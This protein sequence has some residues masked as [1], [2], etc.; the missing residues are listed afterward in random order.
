MV[1]TEPAGQSDAGLGEANDRADHW[2]HPTPASGP[3]DEAAARATGG[4]GRFTIG[5]GAGGQNAVQDNGLDAV[6]WANVNSLSQLQTGYWWQRQ[7]AGKD[8][9]MRAASDALR[10]PVV[11]WEGYGAR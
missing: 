2:Q 5:R 1:R 8:S 4:I 3:L 10:A 11:W 6:D 9:M 7:S